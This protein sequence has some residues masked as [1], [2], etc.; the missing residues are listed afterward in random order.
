MNNDSLLELGPEQKDGPIA[1]PLHFKHKFADSPLFSEMS[2]ANWLETHPEALTDVNINVIHPD[3]KFRIRTGSR[4]GLSGVE[5]LEKVRSG[6]IWINLRDAFNA[7]AEGQALLD[8]AF[9]ELF[10]HNPSFK[11]QKVYANLLISAPQA[12]VPFH[13]DTPDVALFHICGRKRIY[14]YPNIAPYLSDL[15]MERVALRETTEDLLYDPNWDAGAH[16]YD[17]EPGDAVAWPTNAPHR[18][19]NLGT[20][21]ISLS[22]EFSTWSSRL[23]SGAH[24][25]NG[26]LRRRFKMSPVPYSKAGS[27]GIAC[28]WVAS[29]FLKRLNLNKAAQIKHVEEFSMADRQN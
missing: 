28:R 14:I 5:L 10:A 20:L 8:R 15:D 7:S 1:R 13:A 2:I 27:F 24:Y 18:I 29:L 6:E 22:C 17:L 26:T 21:N 23:R 19:D 11:A 3:G 9:G 25:T 16:Y 4:G 12:R